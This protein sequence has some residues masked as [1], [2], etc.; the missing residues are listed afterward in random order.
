M[1]ML[2]RMF[3]DLVCFIELLVSTLV[4]ATYAL[5]IFLSAVWIDFMSSF[6]SSPQENARIS[7]VI[8]ADDSETDNRER[9]NCVMVR[10]ESD[11]HKIGYAGSFMEGHEK[12]PIVLVHGIFGFGAQKLGKISYWGG[13]EKRDDRVL[14]PDLGALTSIHDR[15]RELF[16]YLKGGT[17]DYGVERSEQYGHSRFGHTYHQG[18]YPDWDSKHP[19]HF[20]GHSTGAQVIRLLQNMLADKTFP[21]HEDTSADWVL[22]CTA[23][24]GALNGTTRVYYDGIRPEDG[25]SMKS[26][27]LLQVLRV[28]VLLYEWLDIPILKRYYDFGFD[29][30]NLQWHKAGIRGLVD[31]LRNRRGP[32]VD[33]NWVVPDLSIHSAVQLN[34]K[35]RT[36]D[37]TFYFSYATK[38]TKKWFSRWT[39]PSSV[40]GTHPLLFIRSLQISLW[41][42]PRE[43]PLPYEGYRDEDWLDNDGALNTVSQLYPRVPYEHSNC[44]LGTDLSSLKDGQVLQPGI[45]YYTTLVADHIFFVINRERAGVHFDVLYDNIFQR[46]RKQLRPSLKSS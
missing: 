2:R 25:R 9:S 30:Y 41:R 15:A 21:G 24:S 33:G 35:L 12:A 42:H 37:K 7:P 17:V 40:L 38:G 5:N 22:S 32:F 36:F 31:T 14:A 27:S 4:H 3:W 10:S 16:Y 29:H 46:C 34:K 11:D 43:L 13:A 18:H 28:A 45:W 23:L 1:G 26:V 44:E 39:L 19:I 20:V 6:T 8:E